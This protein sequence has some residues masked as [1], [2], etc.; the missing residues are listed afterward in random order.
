MLDWTEEK[1]QEI[2]E[3]LKCQKARPL[4]ENIKFEILDAPEKQWEEFYRTHQNKFFMDRKWLLNEL[5]ELF[6]EK[7]C[8]KYYKNNNKFIG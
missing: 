1:E 3:T 7:V 5:S 8:K 4:E 6:V 2:D